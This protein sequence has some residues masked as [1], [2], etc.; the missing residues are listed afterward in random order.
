MTKVESLRKK[1]PRFIYK[2]FEFSQK[3][4]DFLISFNFEIPPDISFNPR[5]VIKNTGKVKINKR[6]LSNLVFH[7]GL[8]EIPSYWKCTCSPVIKIEPGNLSQK[9]INWW[10]NLIMKGMGEFFYQNK[11][12][13]KEP[14]FLRIKS[15]K[16]PNSHSVFEKE[17]DNRVLIPIGDGKDS[18][19]TLELLRSAERT[20]GCFSLNPT[21]P[22]QK[23]MRIGNCLN[24]LIVKRNIDS[25]LL[26]LNRQG[27][28]N[29]HTP[30]S[31]Y[32]AFLG[33]LI[34]ILFN[35]KYIAF[36]NE[37]SANQGNT[38]YLGESINHQYSKSFEFEKKFRQYSQKYLAKRVEYFSF[39]RPLY[40]IQIAKLFSRYS[41][42][43]SS[44][45]SCNEAFKTASE[46]K[47]PEQKWCGQ[48]PKCLFVFAALY[49]FLDK[50]DLVPI[51]GKDLFKQR[52]LIDTML[53]L[54]GEKEIK[55][56][57]CVGTIQENLTAFYLSLEKARAQKERPLLLSYF[58]QKILPK[59]K[60]LETQSKK[61]MSSWNSN[62]FL[63][64]DFK[65]LL[66][67]EKD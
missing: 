63:K 10:E 40:E 44:F 46:T 53:E 4:K 20:I 30:F 25:K 18:I 42:Y 32:L 27:F 36:S 24:P 45:I 43:F 21:P 12:N 37:R 33:I 28:L 39:L 56:L 35:F 52:G 60:N 22:A 15:S 29:G 38:K 49:P 66:L 23:I 59:H 57:E 51:F 26:E 50:S 5:M 41:E 16:N 7:L 6:V 19:V 48:C 34:T 1:Y 8:A 11:I 65:D 47:A 2:S 58:E 14:N 67:K 31:S 9:Q 64:E 17:P 61:I 54:I 62:H 55:P 13:F 3:G